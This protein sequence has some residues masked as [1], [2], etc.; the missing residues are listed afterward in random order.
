MIQLLGIDALKRLSSQQLTDV[1]EQALG[2]ALNEEA[3]IMFHISQRRVPVDTGTLK[4]SGMILPLM[5]RQGN[6]IVV[7]GYGGA[8][9]EY[10]QDQHE[11]L[12][13]KHKEGKSAKYLEN[14]IRERLPNLEE[15]L[16]YRIG[17]I[18][19]SVKS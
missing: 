3:Q 2:Q 7:M 5:K 14:P 17:K 12:D 1:T 9:R 6:W 19:G 15:R 4:R 16:A 18:L 8:A 10:A 11:R 13:Y